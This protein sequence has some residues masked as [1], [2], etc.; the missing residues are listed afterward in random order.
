MILLQNETKSEFNE[1][2]F[3][4]KMSEVQNKQAYISF[5]INIYMI[6][7][8]KLLGKTKKTVSKRTQSKIILI[9]IMKKI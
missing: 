1:S 8:Q 6:L 7:T 3:V 4:E 9:N 2:K 5:I